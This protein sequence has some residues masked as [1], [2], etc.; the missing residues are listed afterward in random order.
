MTIFKKRKEIDP[1]NG[2]STKIQ[3]GIRTTPELAKKI[4]EMQAVCSAEKGELVSQN[5]LLSGIIS[6]FVQDIEDTAKVDEELAVN[7]ICGIVENEKIRR[8]YP[9]AQLPYKFVWK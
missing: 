5:I 4:D 3:K 9:E 8:Y 1:Y 2:R 6:E 7:K